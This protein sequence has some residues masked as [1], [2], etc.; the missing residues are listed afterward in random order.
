MKTLMITAPSSNTGKTTLTLGII[1]ALYKRGLNIAG[2]KTGPDFIDTRYLKMASKNGAGN[3]DMHMMGRDNLKKSLGLN[4]SSYA[5]IEGAMGYFDGIYNT[6]ENSSFD[7][8]E[9]LDVPAVLVYRPKGEMFS[10]IPKIKGMVDFSM[11]RIRGIILNKASKSTYLL[12]KEQI[13]KYT[14]VKVLGYLPENEVIRV[15]EDRLGLAESNEED[16]E[17][18]IEK[19][20]ILVEETIDLDSFIDIMKD[21]ELEEFSFG[22]KRKLKVAIA[23]DEAF[24][25]H[26]NENIKILESICQVEYFSPMQDKGL[27]KADL[28]FIGGGYPEK[29]TKELSGN[30][31]MKNS[32]K[33]YVENKGYL[34]CEGGGLM[35]LSNNIELEPMVGIFNGNIKLINKLNGRFGYTVMETKVDTIFGPKAT[36]IVGNEYHKSEMITE[37]DEVFNISKPKSKKV[38]ECGYVYKNVIG[39]YGHINFLGNLELLNN[40][41][42]LVESEEL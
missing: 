17:K 6:F 13:E 24:R 42:D 9:V 34:V 19:T 37:M 39:Y 18:I 38:W 23:K 12:L 33:N 15:D 40:L 32:I 5:V 25:F 27:P 20:S 8:S 3:L 41:L 16:M 2:F 10:A 26:Y 7:M 21:L 28:V 29:Y 11:G 4:K 1:R 31:S 30:L 35:Y 22:R 14:G 36:K